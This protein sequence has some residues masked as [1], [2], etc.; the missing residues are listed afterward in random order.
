MLLYSY[1]KGLGLLYILPLIGDL[2]GLAIVSAA[3]ADLAFHVDVREK[4]HFDLYESIALAVL[5]APSFCV[6]GKTARVVSAHTRRRKV[7]KEVPDW[8]ESS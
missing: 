4:V 5:A 1:N 7:A 8:P 2:K 3:S 6:E